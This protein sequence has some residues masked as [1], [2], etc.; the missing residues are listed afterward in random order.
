MRIIIIVPAPQVSCEG[1][2]KQSEQ[3][4]AN[5]KHSINVIMLLVLNLYV[6]VLILG[7]VLVI[8][9]GIKTLHIIKTTRTKAQYENHT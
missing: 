5:C 1:Y 4:P 7:L 9:H 2:I 8:F 3:W 6:L